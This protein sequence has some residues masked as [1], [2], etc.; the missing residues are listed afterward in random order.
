MN[1]SSKVLLLIIVDLIMVV[2][3]AI[4]LLLKIGLPYLFVF[5][6]LIISLLTIIFLF[7]YNN[8][9][10][11]YWHL[12][13][14]YVLRCSVYFLSTDFSVLPFGDP[15]WDIGVVKTFLQNGNAEVIN[16]MT[17]WPSST[18]AWMSGWPLLHIFSV[19]FV[20]IT[21]L[22][23]M[24]SAIIVTFLF[25]CLFF[26]FVY[27]LISLVSKNI[28]DNIT[29][30]ITLG[31]IAILIF[32]TSPESL[33]WNIQFKYQTIAML[34]MLIIYLIIF[35]TFSRKAKSIDL[36]IIMLI[37]LF[38]IVIGHNLTSM[39]I[40]A[41]LIF[42]V[43]I[44]KIIDRFIPDFNLKNKI[45]TNLA[46]A[47]F[48]FG[49][50]WSLQYAN[51]IWS[52]I[53]SVLNRL[54]AFF[55][56]INSFEKVVVLAS[57]PDILKPTWGIVLLIIRD[58]LMYIPALIGY[59]LLIRQ[60]PKRN[61]YNYLIVISLSIYG[62]VLIANMAIIHIEPL[63]I[64]TYALPFLAIASALFYSQILKQRIVTYFFVVIII[65]VGFIGQWSHNF[66]PLHLWNNLTINNDIGEHNL[67]YGTINNFLN[68]NVGFYEL[69]YADD[70]S[71]LYSLLEPESYYKIRALRRS[72]VFKNN[73]R[74]IVVSFRNFGAYSYSGAVA[75]SNY[76][77]VSTY[78]QYINLTNE[79]RENVNGEMSSVFDCGSIE[80]FITKGV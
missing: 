77:K 47:T 60:L 38:A 78:K 19:I 34:L 54:I 66:I 68:Q 7:K 6:V 69:I 71:L 43:I 76:E 13:F 10:I 26:L 28:T 21:G 5:S 11:I 15:Y 75:I 22:S 2:V 59:L 40:T 18:L 74:S 64:V 45:Y 80:I 25:I 61:I 52:S 63:R 79:I 67:Q 41:Y 9:S 8:T 20:S 35:K 39:A 27:L 4:S 14:V 65:T 51:F 37:T 56:G 55:N 53:G 62:I 3:L 36:T 23:V 57:Y 50:L 16:N 24:N 49:F 1:K 48:V 33:F 70:F 31:P 72:N 32:A 12:F 73:P 44:S 58:L 30:N 29:D 42:V 17:N 46:I